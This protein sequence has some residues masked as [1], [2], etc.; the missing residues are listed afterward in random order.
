LGDIKADI[1]GDI[2][3]VVERVEQR[4][5]VVADTAVVKDTLASGRLRRRRWLI[6]IST[7]GDF[8]SIVRCS[9]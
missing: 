3:A 2:R 9:L 4:N 5:I 1:D 8:I 7:C 6:G